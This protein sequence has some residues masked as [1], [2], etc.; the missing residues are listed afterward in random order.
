MDPSCSSRSCPPTPRLLPALQQALAIL[1]A[2]PTSS[3][4]STTTSGAAVVAV[5]L[6]GHGSNSLL[7][8]ASARPAHDFLLQLQTRNLRRRIQSLQQKHRDTQ[9]QQ[10]Q[11]AQQQQQQAQQQNQD[12]DAHWTGDDLPMGSSWLALLVLLM[13]TAAPA[14]C[15]EP[16]GGDGSGFVA[17]WTERLFCAQSLLQRL[18][19]S[20]V[21]EAMD[22]EMEQ[23][24]EM[25]VRQIFSFFSDN[26]GSTISTSTSLPPHHH[27]HCILAYQQLVARWNPFVAAV[28]ETARGTN[29]MTSLQLLPQHATGDDSI[30]EELIKAEFGLW[31][32]VAVAFQ[33]AMAATDDAA[34]SS[35]QHHGNSYDHHQTRP[36]LETLGFAIATVTLRIW[37]HAK[38]PQQPSPASS[39]RRLGQHDTRRISN[40][41][42]CCQ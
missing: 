13:A 33:T 36:L 6:S 22:W 1:Y 7:D 39:S 27:E 38:S 9:Q 26:G 2:L 3:S 4:S 32:L 16:G 5:V 10:Q 34:I 31:T 18:R 15:S 21:V 20:K 29:K 14:A 30:A 35:T 24:H 19:R 41:L 37:N 42:E 25:Q 8:P 40:R 28:L 11:Q 12:D 17:C 23:E